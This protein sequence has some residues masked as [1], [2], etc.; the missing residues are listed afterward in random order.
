MSRGKPLEFAEREQIARG[1]DR[2][3]HAVVIA[4]KLG[5]DPSV[6]TREISRNG[7]RE[8]YSAVAAQQRADRQKS[9][10][11]ARKLEK[12]TELHDVVNAGLVKKWSPQQIAGRLVRDYPD[13]EV[14][15]VSSETIYETLFVQARGE[16]RTQLKL[17]LRTGRTQRVPAGSSRPKQARIVGMTLI[18][19]RPAAVADRAVPGHWESD[20][21]VGARNASQIL[22]LVER[23]TRFV[24]LQ[25]IPYDRRAER[26]SLLLAECVQQL[27]AILWRSITHDQGVEMADHARF[28]IKTNIPI[29][30]CDPHSPW[31][32][33]SNENTNG[34][35]RQYFPKSTD[36]SVYSQADLDAVAAELNGRPR[37]I[38]DWCTPAEL[39]NEHL[40]SQ[41]ALTG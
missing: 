2:T 41:N 36:L 21:I 27:P 29:F 3:W 34:L 20:L 13:R 38:L 1:I 37:E 30:F 28:T 39:L 19:D 7:G 40:A 6:V 11:Q 33:G 22:T 24:L 35:L 32:R 10:P 23:T 16:C 31:Q 17:A 4:R 8:K 5:R 26:V 15:R 14:M 18:S 9:R 12:N 25:K